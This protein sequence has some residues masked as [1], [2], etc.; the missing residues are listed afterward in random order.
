MCYIYIHKI[1]SFFNVHLAKQ[2]N[3]THEGIL[4]IPRDVK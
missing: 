4:P 2:I 1:Y 3:N